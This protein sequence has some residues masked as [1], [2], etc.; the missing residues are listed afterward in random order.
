MEAM[1]RET[2]PFNDPVSLL[3]VVKKRRT[4][5]STK[6]IDKSKITRTPKNEGTAKCGENDVPNSRST[7]KPRGTVICETQRETLWKISDDISVEVS[8]ILNG[9][10]I[11]T[12][13]NLAQMNW[14]WIK[15]FVAKLKQ[16]V[17]TKTSSRG[18]KE[19]LLCCLGEAN[20]PDDVDL[21]LDKQIAV[22]NNQRR[23]GENVDKEITG[24]QNALD[25]WKL[26]WYSEPLYG[27][28]VLRGMFE[29]IRIV[30]V[31]LTSTH[32]NLFI[33]TCNN[34]CPWIEFISWLD[35][36]QPNMRGYRLKRGGEWKCFEV[37]KSSLSHNSGLFAQM[38]ETN[39]V[40]EENQCV[41]VW[42]ARPRFD[43]K[44]SSP[45]RKEVV[46][47]CWCAIK[48]SWSLKTIG[49]G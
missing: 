29:D 41:A 12:D 10:G 30:I 9:K 44:L 15:A 16:V 43:G 48:G 39:R 26:R 11:V 47:E 27:M 45:W 6:G 23:W 34:F 5:S 46:G 14:H 37:S 17:Q 38:A 7:Q 19:T 28:K 25:N 36:K 21:V 1:D 24:L 31:W 20:R 35:I 33:R 42:K 2:S 8:P 32:R 49:E 4:S 22:A 3:A 18:W 40:L 13:Y